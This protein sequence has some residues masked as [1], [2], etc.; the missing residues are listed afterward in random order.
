[1]PELPQPMRDRLVSE[2][3]LSA[4]DASWVTSTRAHAGYF[5]AVLES[6]R[7]GDKLAAAK[8]VANWM[9]S[10]LAAALNRDD[11]DIARSRVAP[12]SLANL[13]KRHADGTLSGKMAR[14]V[15]GQMW[16]GDGEADDI[17]GRRGL[18]QVSDSG[19]LEKL[20]DDV[21]AGHPKSVDEYKSGKEKALNALL[22]QVMK[23]SNRTANPSQVT[24]ILKR[25]LSG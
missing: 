3:D 14:E 24:E 18:K 23:A 1:M 17:I 10:D 9:T 5:V 13:L 25:K 19:A 21:I 12:V 2:F 20:V 16:A 11:L 4:Y 22:G 7:D 15:F 6:F 8:Q